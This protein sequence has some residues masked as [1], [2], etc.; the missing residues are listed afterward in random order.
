MKGSNFELSENLDFIQHETINSFV[1]YKN[2]AE[3]KLFKVLFLIE[4]NED[5]FLVR[6]PK[7]KI[8]INAS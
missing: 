8:R 1:V 3:Y 2:K 5:L 6:E 7:R 4:I